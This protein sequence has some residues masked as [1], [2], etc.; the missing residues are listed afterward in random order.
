MD[1]AELDNGTPYRD[2]QAHMLLEKSFPHIKGFQSTLLHSKFS[3]A[4][5][6][7][8]ILMVRMYGTKIIILLYYIIFLSAIQAAQ[9][10]HTGE[11]NWVITVLSK[12]EWH[13]LAVWQVRLFHLY[14]WPKSMH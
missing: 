8:K 14:S 12:Y 2:S 5:R 7:T 4:T 13:F 1:K 11:S 10:H 3:S 9:I 6:L